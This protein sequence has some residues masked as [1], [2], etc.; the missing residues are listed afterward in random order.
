M[1][2]QLILSLFSLVLLINVNSQ[3]DTSLFVTDASLEIVS[4]YIYRGVESNKEPSLQGEAN[5]S[6]SDFTFGVWASSSVTGGYFE[7]DLYLTY[8]WDN[9]SFTL[10]DYH[11][12][13]GL[14]YFNY[15]NDETAHINELSIS[16]TLN[17]SIPLTISASTIFYGA[18]KKTDNDDNNYSSYLEL[19]YPINLQAAT[20]TLTGGMTTHESDYY[21]SEGTAIINLNASFEKEI[22]INEQFSLPIGFSTIVNPELNRLYC[23][24]SI[25][26]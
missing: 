3:S 19:S 7:P 25:H 18:D 10:N 4:R 23:V 24:L 22:K 1:K 6:F 26:F 8:T 17:E 20:L 2:N 16:Y 21:Q 9:L 12:G 13:E 5:I 14:D 15:K 11:V